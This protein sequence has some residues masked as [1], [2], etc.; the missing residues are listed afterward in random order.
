MKTRFRI[1]IRGILSQ[2]EE[3]MNYIA[4]KYECQDNM[5]GVRRGIRMI[6]NTYDDEF[7]RLRRV[8]FALQDD[9]KKK[10]ERI[11]KLISYIVTMKQEINELR[12]KIN[13]TSGQGNSTREEDNGK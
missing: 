1:L 12:E 5:E 4:K 6:M 8:L 9:C 13:G 11:T 3:V 7:M 2:T 10:D